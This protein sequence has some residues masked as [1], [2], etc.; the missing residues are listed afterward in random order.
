LLPQ[1]HPLHCLCHTQHDVPNKVPRHGTWHKT[2]TRHARTELA[3]LL[4]CFV[5]ALKALLLH[6]EHVLLAFCSLGRRLSESFFGQ[7]PLQREEARSR[8]AA[9]RANG[10]S[11]T[12]KAIQ[13]RRQISCRCRSCCACTVAVLFVFDWRWSCCEADS[14]LWGSLWHTCRDHVSKRGTL[15]RHEFSRHIRERKGESKASFQEQMD[16]RPRLACTQQIGLVLKFQSVCAPV[17][18]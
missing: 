6:L 18:K 1:G 17:V 2:D 10:A 7:G 11:R 14:R 9:P 12:T 16:H 4:A 3:Y 15:V 5:R 8:Y 13:H